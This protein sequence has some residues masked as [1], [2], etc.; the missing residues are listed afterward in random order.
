VYSPNELQHEQ[1]THDV[2]ERSVTLHCDPAFFLQDLGLDPENTPQPIRAFLQS[3][4]IPRS[5]QRARLSARMRQATIELMKPPGAPAFARAFREVKARDLALS[6]LILLSESEHRAERPGQSG[7]KRT[8]V[9]TAPELRRATD[10]LHENLGDE[11]DLTALG[12]VV[13]HDPIRFARAFKQSTGFSVAQYRLRARVDRAR[14]LLVE[15]KLPIKVISQDSG[16]YDQAHFTRA[17]RVA[18][19]TTPLQYRQQFSAKKS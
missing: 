8:A 6:L 16:F 11:A 5:F 10:W 4:S 3:H 1:L 17:F 12:R 18:F 7:G 15:G 14:H 2:A 19:G 9:L 13:G